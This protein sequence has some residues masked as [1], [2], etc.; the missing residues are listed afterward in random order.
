MSNQPNIILFLTD[1]HARWALGAYDDPYVLTPNLDYM[2][3]NGV[4]MK[5]ASTPNPVCSPARAC[6]FT[7][8]IPSQHGIHDY[9]GNTPN[10]DENKHWLKEEVPIQALFKKGGYETALIGKW[11]LGQEHTDK[12]HFDYSFTIGTEYPILHGENRT[13]YKGSE[14]VECEGSLT[15]TITNEALRYLK[16]RDRSKPLF[17]VIGH[18]A[19]HS[20]WQGHRERLVDYY[21][22]KNIVTRDQTQNYSFGSQ[23]NESLDATRNNPIEALSQY[24]AAVSQIDE[25]VGSVLDEIEGQKLMDQTLFVYTSDHGLNCGDHGLWGKGNATYPLNLLD[26]SIQVPLVFYGP[27]IL[28]NRQKRSEMVNHTDLFQTLLDIG[29]IKE[30]EEEKQKRNSPGISF[31]PALTNGSSLT[32]WKTEQFYEYG[33]VRMIRTKKYKLILYPDSANNLLIDLVNDPDEIENLYRE[34]SYG[35]II[36]VLKTKINIF[37]DQFTSDHF[38]G[39]K[40]LDTLPQYNSLQAWEP[41]KE[42]K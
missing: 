26:R 18:Y 20:Q 10:R 38:D 36:E 3:R 42:R 19:T 9:L 12:E 6:L 41:E 39:V 35:K 24:Y 11:H 28:F 17:L 15:R 29:E 25:S 14:K 1:D 37:F 22:Q 16:E 34:E 8:R 23:R 13:F 33:P 40:C 32:N 21:R 30:S 31:A 7:G 4:L 5:E 27:E 2:A